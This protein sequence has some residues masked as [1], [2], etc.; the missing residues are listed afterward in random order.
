MARSSATAPEQS[1][2][3]SILSRSAPWPK[4]GLDISK[5]VSKGLAQF[6]DEDFDY[7]IS[8][9]ARAAETCPTWPRS[10][11]QIRWHFDDPAEAA[12]PEEDRLGVFRRVR[13]EIQQR[14]SLMMLA[15][16]IPMRLPKA[17]KA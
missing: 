8:V 10:R 2:S 9:C 16:K 5:N 13:N 4:S 6:L 15:A 1:P 11:E 7:V 17:S 14:L 12:A 3:L